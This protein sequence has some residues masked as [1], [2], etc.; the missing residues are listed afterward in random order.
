MPGI[1]AAPQPAQPGHGD[2]IAAVKA[3]SRARCRLGGACQGQQSGH[4][5][6]AKGNAQ[7]VSIDHFGSPVQ[8]PGRR[9]QRGRVPAVREPAAAG[10]G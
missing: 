9:G 8:R 4:N 1:A 10:E 5:Q 6:S 2:M 7:H 3:A